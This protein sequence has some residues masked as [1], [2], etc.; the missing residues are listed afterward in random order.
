MCE[1][2][3]RMAHG[4]HS[5]FW[6]ESLHLNP[7]HKP[8]AKADQP[9]ELLPAA[10]SRVTAALKVEYS[11]LSEQASTNLYPRPKHPL[12]PSTCS[13]HSPNSSGS[14]EYQLHGEAATILCVTR[15][16]NI[17]GRQSTSSL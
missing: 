3:V 1:L 15:L 14:I 9:T 6:Q 12:N 10:W 17:E 7:N 11:M 4:R 5:P 2:M 8:Y 13:I 16:L